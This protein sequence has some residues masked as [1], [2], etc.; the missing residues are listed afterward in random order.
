MI[1]RLLQAALLAAVFP[2]SMVFADPSVAVVSHVKVVSDKVED[3]SSLGE[4]QKSVINPGMTDAQK[5]L[6][7]W[8]TAV[9]FRHHDVPAP[10]EFLV[11]DGLIN[12]AIKLYNVYGY[13]TGGPAQMSIV[14]LARYSG[15]DARH[16]SIFRWGVPEIFYDGE[17]HMYDAGMIN[18]FPKADGKVASVEELV[19]AVK[20][21]HKD[22]PGY[23]DNGDKLKAYMKNPG[24]KSGPE[25][26][27]RC[28]T[29]QPNGAFTFN[30]FGWY[31]SMIVYDVEKPAF[32]YEEPYSQGYKVNNQLRRGERLTFNWGN[33]GMHVGMLDTPRKDPDS[34]TAKVGAKQLAYTSKLGDLAN[35]RIGNGELVYTP[36]LADP[37]FKASA[38]KFE[39]LAAGPGALNVV[40]ASK[41]GVLEIAMPCSYVYL[42]GTLDITT[43]LP[44]GATVAVQ[45]SDNNGLDWKDL[46][47]ISQ[48]GA[49]TID[50]QKLVIRRYD[51]R[52]KLTLTGK[53]T[54]SA[55]SLKHDF[56][57]SQ[58]ALPA[59]TQGENNISFSAGPT[60][61]T[62]TIEHGSPKNKEK[63]LTH[64]SFHATLNRIKKQPINEYGTFSPDGPT[65]DVSYTVETPGDLAR[66][67][68]GCHYR[69]AA[70]GDKW[71]FQVSFDEGKTFETVG[72]ATGPTRGNAKWVTVD[73]IPKGARRAIVRF[74]GTQKNI[75]TLFHSRIDADYLQPAGG[76][77]PVNVTYVWEEDGQEKRHEHVAKAPAESYKIPCST[78]P[79]MKSLTFELAK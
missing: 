33:K 51:Y 62:V 42:T 73:K 2:I 57:H 29:L 46:E 48:P 8:E 9:K 14:Q 67:R 79:T 49:K 54:I 34:L 28:P 50:L 76:F 58:R 20:A 17:W 45:L 25:L 72:T 19:A 75:L 69:A 18:Y 13:T 65:G 44:D 26:L 37:A 30:S 4:W 1:A 27:T 59:L 43:A 41:A 53:A 78:K 47:T 31:S 71:E 6:A 24:I 77:S 61:G 70:D 15:F 32:V 11:S 23:H 66:L 40:D 10:R 38:I 60:E 7:I 52:L 63:Q 35:G 64:E 68:F 3:V 5:A 21:W 36:P 16:M 12:D 39:N 56:Q 55:L 22:N 74:L